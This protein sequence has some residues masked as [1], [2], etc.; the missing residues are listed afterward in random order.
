LLDDAA[1][2]KRMSSSPEFIFRFLQN[3]P[4]FR[5][6]DSLIFIAAAYNPLKFAA[7]L[8]KSNPNLQER[9]RTIKNIHLRK[10]ISLVT[11]KNAS[12]L[13]PFATVL[14]ENRIMADTILMARKNVTTYF[15]LL[16]NMLKQPQG[17]NDPSLFFR[18]CCVMG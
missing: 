12:E 2:Y 1:V 6:A 7:D 10:I 15:Q 16:V 11:D 14:A 5:Y 3:K 9:I 17:A 13:L 8:S 18:S 4:E